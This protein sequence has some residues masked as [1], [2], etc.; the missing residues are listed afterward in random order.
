MTNTNTAEFCVTCGSPLANDASRFC[1]KCGA[2]AI[3]PT[4]QPAAPIFNPLPDGWLTRNQPTQPAPTINQMNTQIVI[5]LS[6]ATKRLITVVTFGL[7][8]VV[9]TLCHF[10]WHWSPSFFLNLQEW[11]LIFAVIGVALVFTTGRKAK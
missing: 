2:T 5:S 6:P 9:A 11:F 7:L 10:V 1:D 8:A 3:Q 4:T